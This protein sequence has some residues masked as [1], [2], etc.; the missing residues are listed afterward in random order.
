[1]RGDGYGISQQGESSS[2]ISARIPEVRYTAERR[3]G[4]NITVATTDTWKDKA[5][6]RRRKP[7]SGI[8]SVLLRQA[9][10]SRRPVPEEGLAGLRRGRIRTRKWTDK[11]GQ[12]RYTTEIA[13]MK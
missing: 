4:A 6:A 3:G 12:E 7:P 1:L 2:G 8:A 10:R 5:T 13:A 9:G 11:E